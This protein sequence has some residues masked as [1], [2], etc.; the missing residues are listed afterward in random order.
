[1]AQQ[2]APFTI[3]SEKATNAGQSTNVDLKLL[4]IDV[5]NDNL[6][7][8][9]TTSEDENGVI[10]IDNNT[11]VLT[12][13][14]DKSF[15][16]ISNLIFVANDGIDD[17][18]SATIVVDVKEKPNLSPVA[19]NNHYSLKENSSVTFQLKGYDPE[20][21]ENLKYTLLNQTQQGSIELNSDNGSVIYTPNTEYFGDDSFNFYIE[22]SA[23][24]KSQEST[25]ELTI[26]QLPNNVPVGS[27]FSISTNQDETVNLS[28]SGYDSDGDDLVFAIENQTSNGIITID[29]TGLGTYVPKQGYYGKDTFT[30]S[31]S[32]G[33]DTSSSSNGTISVV[34][35]K[36][37]APIGFNS[38]S[39]IGYNS[40]NI[41]IQPTF[42][43]AEDDDVTSSIVEQA[44]NGIAVKI[45]SSDARNGTLEYTPN[46]DFYG[47]D[48][49]TYMLNDGTSDSNHITQFMNII[50]PGD[51]NADGNIN[52]LDLIFLSSNIVGI[53]GF[54]IPTSFESV[55][56]INNDDTIN[57]V[58][59]IFLAS[60]IVGIEGFE[61]IP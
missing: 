29:E 33:N 59:L 49:F 57:S 12:Y 24:L 25:I 1:V 34:K 55:F 2:I 8:S 48:S 13:T 5:N 36:N 37:N 32:D 3:G 21:E 9:A 60:Y 38:T 31:V 43:D 58:D 27:P 61:L 42:E 23:Q 30:F 40:A 14:P 53:T 50:G 47:S 7:F 16:G 54:D 17:S 6:T 26:R 56:N 20:G 10:G 28:L 41:T 45:V 39:L 46:L 15:S 51:L 4:S 19:Y 18:N 11:G 52:S 35:L 22:D 44:I